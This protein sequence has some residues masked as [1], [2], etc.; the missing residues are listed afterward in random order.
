M[1]NSNISRNL[2]IFSMF[3]YATIFVQLIYY[4]VLGIDSATGSN[5]YKDSSDLDSVVSALYIMCA[6]F[7]VSVFFG[8]CKGYEK[9]KTIYESYLLFLI[10][11]ATFLFASLA[12]VINDGYLFGQVA[13]PTS[14]YISLMYNVFLFSFA[15][16]MF[17]NYCKNYRDIRALDY[18]GNSN[19]P[20]SSD[21]GA[22]HSSNQWQRPNI[23][24]QQPGNQG[25]QPGNQGPNGFKAF[26]GKAYRL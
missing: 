22:E 21:L 26:S 17:V 19:L 7:I 4:S 16:V 15:F 3:F 9:S 24:G 13:D 5:F 20:E 18:L 14:Q 1:L 25:Q 8:V 10:T 11:M 12:L 6:L 23:Q 2:S